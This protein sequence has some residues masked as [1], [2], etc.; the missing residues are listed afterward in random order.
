MKFLRSIFR[1]RSIGSYPTRVRNV[2]HLLVRPEAFDLVIR[3]R[4]GR[5]APMDFGSVGQGF[6]P[7]AVNSSHRGLDVVHLEAHVVDAQ[8]QG[9]SVLAGLEFQ[10]GNVEMT[11]GEINP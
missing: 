3:L 8:P 10:D 5:I 9:L 11:I 1:R 6:T 4:P 2:N 7:E